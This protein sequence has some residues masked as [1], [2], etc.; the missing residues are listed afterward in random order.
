M[1]RF[2]AAALLA[3]FILCL[4][5]P[6]AAADGEWSEEYY[7]AVDLTG[8]TTDAEEV[9]LD[10]NCID[11]INEFGV[12]LA[13]LAVN[14]EY[15]EGHTLEEIAEDFYDHCG[16]GVG[17]TR[18]G[19]MAVYDADTEE[20]AVF[21]FGAADLPRSDLKFVVDTAT[22]FRSEYGI[23]G[24]MYGTYKSLA[25][26]LRSAA[27]PGGIARVG[28]GG[29]LPAWYP[30][31]VASFKP[32]RD[33]DAP[34][35]RDDADIFSDEDEAWLTEV[36]LEVRADTGRDVVVYTDMSEYGL[37]HDV[38]AA[39]Y[40][41]FNGYGTGEQR[42]GFCLYID[43]DPGN[44]GWWTAVHG[45]DSRGVY[46]YENANEIDDALY[47]Y[48]AGGN[49]AYGVRD[50]ADNIRTLCL[51][52]IP[53]APEWYPGRDYVKEHDPDAPRVVDET[54]MLNDIELGQLEE[55]A[56][57]L[58]DKL[59]VDV[60]ILMCGNTYNM[61]RSEYADAFYNY[62]G[63]GFGDDY[64]GVLLALYE[65][66]GSVMINEYG[67]GLK[68]LTS[69][70]YDRLVSRCESKLRSGRLLEAADEW[71]RLVGRM[72][73]TGRVPRTT[74]AWCGT[75]FLGAVI[76]C[77]FGGIDRSR[78][79]AK[80]RT[81]AVSTNANAYLIPAAISIL[82]LGDVFIRTT[83]SSQYSP[84]RTDSGGGSGR[85]SGGGSSHSSSYSS[86]Y[87]SSSGSSYSGSGRR[88]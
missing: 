4:L 33:A 86:S 55:K 24:V 65:Y 71:L 29:D 57:A 46:T 80:M 28:E 42:E 66:S 82:S 68:H 41:E 11:F 18:D 45:L 47:E 20:L 73:R 43:M 59:G 51:K 38:C 52:G 79:K 64:D 83:S 37:G 44:R 21:C 34:R 75:G 63:Y 84:I 78:A 15:R 61:S 88:F 17:E 67:A 8:E 6:L 23:F 9:S 7:R 2:A 5:A 10:E 12:D 13:M 85:S 39:D 56:A 14:T 19:Y 76:G 70:N 49:Y 58:S 1:K 72:E 26:R 27:D 69:V 87:S 3:L 53:F 74:A 36:L 35:V 40:F 54:H 30:V 60:V 48:M 62:T 25:E 50:W 16:F 77:I 22:G 31:D 81:P 32:Y